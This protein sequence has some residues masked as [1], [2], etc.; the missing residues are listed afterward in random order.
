MGLLIPVISIN[1]SH[2]E[3]SNR[4]R[5]NMIRIGSRR[6][7]GGRMEGKGS[8]IIRPLPILMGIIRRILGVIKQP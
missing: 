1:R 3:R 7:K 4:K 2:K 6:E 8:V 5:D